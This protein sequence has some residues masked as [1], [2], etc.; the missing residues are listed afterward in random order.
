MCVW[1]REIQGHPRA[2]LHRVLGPPSHRV[3]LHKQK[4]FLEF[5][6]FQGKLRN[7]LSCLSGLRSCFPWEYRCAQ[8]LLWLWFCE[9]LLPAGIQWWKG[10]ALM[11]M[12]IFLC[13]W[14]GCFTSGFLCSSCPEQQQLGTLS[15]EICG[16]SLCSALAL[17]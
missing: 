2:P 15:Q 13:G 17:S 10:L 4:G 5:L 8:A 6:P 3:G 7:E 14:R 12:E 11:E 16:F 9:S 1:D